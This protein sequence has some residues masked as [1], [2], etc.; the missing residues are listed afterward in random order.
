MGWDV[1][2]HPFAPT[3]VR[4]IYFRALRDEAFRE[5]LYGEFA[6]H[7]SD[8]ERLASIFEEAA[9]YVAEDHFTKYHGFA[10]ASVA[11]FLRRY[12]YIRGSAFT[13]LVEEDPLYF[14]YVTDWRSLI[15]DEFVTEDFRGIIC[16]NYCGG[17]FLGPEGL[18]ALKVDYE[19]DEQ[20]RKDM[21]KLFS[22]GRLPVFWK[23]VD[24]ALENG[25][26][27]IEAT[28]VLVPNPFAYDQ[29]QCYSQAL[30]CETEG[31]VL[32]GKAIV[33]QAREAECI[34]HARKKGF[35][36]GLFRR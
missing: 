23:A 17:V 6:V 31:V 33:E 27:L 2:Y 4:G 26:G 24:Y 5:Q 15:P 16:E 10:M 18:R 1:T 21:D 8:A 11:G 13:F 36:A 29:S 32:Y 3:E 9:T 19:R 22:H 28:D 25:L 14:R 30:H 20:V 7:G 34:E 35:W 12:W